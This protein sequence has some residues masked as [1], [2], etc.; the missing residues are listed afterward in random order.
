MQESDIA[1][2]MAVELRA[3]PHPWSEG[4][5]RDCL[6]SGYHCKLALYDNK[7]IGH[8]VMSIAADESHL[9]NIAIDPKCHGQGYGRTLLKHMLSLAQQKNVGTIFLEVRDSNH[10]AAAL[11]DSVGF[12]EVGR[13]RGYYPAKKGREDAI[14]YGLML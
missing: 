1:I 2:V 10:T 4:V 6:R 7:V 13:R 14:V 3:Y 12:N 11:Y 9:L 5:M 8:S